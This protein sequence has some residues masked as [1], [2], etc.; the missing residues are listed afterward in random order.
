M[1]ANID[2]AISD[3]AEDIGG[4]NLTVVNDYGVWITQMFTEAG[5]NPPGTFWNPDSEDERSV[6]DWVIPGL[7]TQREIN[8]VGDGQLG[9][10]LAINTVLR[11]LLAVKFAT[12][13][14][15]ITANQETSV[16]T[17]YT[18]AWA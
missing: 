16:V 14:G 12:I 1:S 5:F 17:A 10:N 11:T 13:A 6:Y 8:L 7:R 9:A 3:I 18:N 4:A 15:R 2:E